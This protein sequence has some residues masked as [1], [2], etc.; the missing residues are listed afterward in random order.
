MPNWCYN[1]LRVSGEAG[2]SKD[3]KEMEKEQKEI[4]KEIKKFVK[5]NF[6]DGRLTFKNAV[7][8]PKELEITSGSSTDNAIDLIKAKDGDMEGI[9]KMIGWQWTAGTCKYKERDSIDDKRVKII[10]YLQ[11]KLTVKEMK[12]GQQALDNIEKY[13]YKDWY[14]WS[15]H[16]WGTKWDACEGST[17]ISDYEVEASFDTAW[18]PPTPWLEKVSMKYKKL[19]F[20]L[21]YTEEGMGFEG[22]A[23]AKAGDIV[24]NSMNIDYPDEYWD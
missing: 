8:M 12:E 4:K 21:E 1:N 7:P 23:F 13:G 22:K 9:D 20:E 11:D 3:E 24:D 5:E 6:K 2:Y 16:N 14:N 17:H 18:A 15:L 19:R 10:E